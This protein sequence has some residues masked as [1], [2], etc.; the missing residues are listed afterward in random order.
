LLLVPVLVL[1]LALLRSELLAQARHCWSQSDAA[2]AAANCPF[3]SLRIPGAAGP[4]GQLPLLS[5]A[6]LLALPQLLELAQV[7]RVLKL[8]ASALYYA[9]AFDDGGYVPV[10][11]WL[12]R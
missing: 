3:A 5:R 7:Q 11:H 2:A 6:S 12:C 10:Y 8:Q 9:R 1:V 4:R